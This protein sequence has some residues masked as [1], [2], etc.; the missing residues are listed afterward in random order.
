MITLSAMSP[1]DA[2]VPIL[3][4]FSNVLATGDTISTIVAVTVS[5]SGMT[6][7]TPTIAAGTRTACAVQVKV[8]S[9]GTV[10]TLYLVTAEITSAQGIQLARSVYI[11]V[12]IV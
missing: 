12:A 3:L 11:P 4:D 7:G 5:P 8:I 9:P 1:S 6:L 10:A 2:D